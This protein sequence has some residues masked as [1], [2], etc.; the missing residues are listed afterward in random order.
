[1]DDG[2]KKA[3]SQTLKSNPK[4]TFMDKVLQMSLTA[5]AFRSW[6]SGL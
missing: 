5:I 2:I 1:M 3:I 6:Q 4:G